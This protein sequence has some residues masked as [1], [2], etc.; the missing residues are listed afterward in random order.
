MFRKSLILKM[1]VSERWCIDVVIIIN[2]MVISVIVLF[3]Y[4]SHNFEQCGQV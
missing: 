1:A 4:E 3:K 2:V